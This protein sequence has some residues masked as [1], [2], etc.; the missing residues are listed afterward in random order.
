M[1]SA[2]EASLRWTPDQMNKDNALDQCKK[3][4]FG[5]VEINCG[6][7]VR[8]MLLHK[9]GMYNLAGVLDARLI[10]RAG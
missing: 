9:R 8:I 4:D 3:S 7:E 6:R 1:Q 2:Y 10:Q 5:M